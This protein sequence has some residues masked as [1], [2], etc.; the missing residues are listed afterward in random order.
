MRKTLLFVTGI[1]EKSLQAGTMDTAPYHVAGQVQTGEQARRLLAKNRYDALLVN[2]PLS[3]EPG[4]ALA[5]YAA[6]KGIS[7]LLLAGPEAFARVSADVTPYGVFTLE[8]PVSK[9]VFTQVLRLMA[10]FDNRLHHLE[11]EK[12]QQMRRRL[13]E[14]QVISRAKCILVEYLRMNEDQAHKYI[15]RQAMDMQQS[16][17]Q[18]A[19]SILKTYED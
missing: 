6:E 7:I 12:E 8:K 14:V 1:G 2:M 10:V 17:R 4:E 5:V 3:D 15:E 18:V 19:E 9:G 11:T 13:E 16:K